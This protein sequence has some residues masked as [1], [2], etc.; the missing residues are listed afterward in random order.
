[1]VQSEVAGKKAG[2]SDHLLVAHVVVPEGL[3]YSEDNGVKQWSLS[4]YFE[5]V[6]DQVIQRV[7]AHGTVFLSPGNTFGC[8]ST[9][10]EY[11]AQYL[12]SKRPE[13]K[14]FVPLKMGDRSY[15]D[16]FD[17]AR[18]LRSWLQTQKLWTLGKVILYCNRPHAF[19]SY[20]LFR[21]CGFNVTQ[22]V[23]IRPL[24]VSRSMVSRLWFYNY[25][26]VQL[27]YEAAGMLYGLIRWVI[28]LRDRKGTA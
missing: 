2:E 23:A 19:R 26:P 16:T 7:P 9:E 20:L 8:E 17:N 12:A 13:L 21:L 18:L 25:L 11:A 3:A 14:V 10:E 1:M 27:L 28:W 4:D 22:V 15:L 6:L 24:K 5:A